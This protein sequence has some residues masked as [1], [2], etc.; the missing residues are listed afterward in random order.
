M[1]V[2]TIAAVSAILVLTLTPTSGSNDR[3]LVPFSDIGPALRHPLDVSQSFGV[4]ANI[5]LFV[6]L[7]LVLCLRT[8]SLRRTVAAGL[9]LSVGIE[10]AQL[11]IPGRTTSFDDVLLNTVG[12]ALG[13]CT[14]WRLVLHR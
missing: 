1:R 7:G 8:W 13:W 2:P 6:P 12:V 11:F 9:A 4:P 3:E 5:A 14:A 10:I